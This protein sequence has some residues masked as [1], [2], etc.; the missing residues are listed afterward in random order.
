[1]RP[2]FALDGNYIFRVNV[3]EKKTSGMGIGNLSTI[4]IFRVLFLLVRNDEMFSGTCWKG[5]RSK[6]H[7]LIEWFSAVTYKDIMAKLI[8][9]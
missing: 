9:R 2:T 6:A 7:P 8:L 4:Y 3:R 1:L 5:Y